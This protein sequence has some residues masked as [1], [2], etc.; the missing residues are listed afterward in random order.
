MH[1]LATQPGRIDNQAAVD[2]DQSPADIVILSAADTELACLAYAYRAW[3]GDKP[4]LRLANLTRLGHPFSVDLY[5][6]KTL[7]RAK[8]IVVRLLGGRAYW[9]YGIEEIAKLAGPAKIFLLPGDDKPDFDLRRLSRC[10]D[11]D[12]ALVGRYFQEG[13]MENAQSMLAMLSAMVGFSAA[14][15]PPLVLPRHGH[16]RLSRLDD[17]PRVLILFYRAL[18]QAG[19]TQAIDALIDALSARGLAACPLYVH[20]LKDDAAMHFVAAES[21]RAR[22]DL[23]LNLLSFAQGWDEAMYR[24]LFGDAPCLQV[25]LSG[26]SEQAW[27][28]DHRGLVPR[29]LA[30]QV[31]LPEIDGKVTTRA[32]AFKSEETV[33]DAVQCPIVTPRVLP[34]RVDYVCDLAR[35]WIDLRR[36]PASGKRIGIILANYPNRDGRIGNGVGLDVPR[37]LL[38]LLDALARD[39]YDVAAPA[40]VPALMAMLLSGPTNADPERASTVRLPLEDYRTFFETF[41][42]ERREEILA[43]WGAPD[44]DPFVRDGAFNLAVHALDQV[45][46]G[47]Q[48]ARGYQI[49]PVATYHDAT[50]PP[51]HYYLAFYCYLREK[52]AALIHL[53]KHGTA[54]WLPGK[55]LALSRTCWPEIVLGPTPHFYPFIVNDPGE[56]T[57]AKRR[58]AAVILDHLTPPLTRAGLHGDLLSLAHLIEEYYQASQLDPRRLKELRVRI[59]A[60]IRRQ[61]LD[62]DCGLRPGDDGEAALAKIDA[63]LCALKELQIRDGLHVFGERPGGTQRIDLLYALLHL[64]RGK[65]EGKDQSLL[66]ALALDKKVGFDPLECDLDHRTGPIVEELRELACDLLAGKTRP[67]STW[68]HILPVLD[69]AEEVGALLDRSA[70]LEIDHMLAGLRGEYVPPGPSGA[71]SRGRLDV[72]PTGRNFY[73]VD[74]RAIPTMTAWALGWKSASLLLERHRQDHGEWPRSIM[75]SAWGTANMRTGGDDIA[76]A[77]ALIGARPSWDE[78]GRVS[79]FEILPIGIL[80]RPRVDVTLRISGF[81]RDAFPTQIELFDS[82]VRAI[83]ALAEEGTD[84]ALA[85]HMAEE[86]TRLLEAGVPAHL[87]E[88]RAGHRVFGAKPG[89]YGTGL[90][91]LIDEGIWADVHDLGA[92]FI[93]WGSH[94]YGTQAQGDYVPEQFRERLSRAEA[95][96]HNQDNREHDIL[97]SDDYYQFEGGLT[98]AIRHVTGATPP[99]WHNDHSNPNRPKIAPLQ[100]E[101]GRIVRG[102]AANP[103]WIAGAMRHGYKGALEMAASVDY[104]FAFAATTGLVQDHHFQALYDAYIGN[105]KVREFLDDHNPAALREMTARFAEALRRGLWKSRSNSLAIELATEGIGH[106]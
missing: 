27:Q 23:I 89:A 36:M 22:P 60:E 82:A 100:E 96:V 97:D 80:G 84:N 25:L 79:G 8:I 16:Y 101:L 31:V 5:A 58:T 34:E 33:D 3:R 20:S 59:L 65:G 99:V 38:V 17:R 61:G 76:Q 28:A 6:E 103:K 54:E 35:A 51:P 45:L 91:T 48:P 78:T 66:R 4:S 42:P 81:F 62:K 21:Q 95:V 10:D 77:M 71:P 85:H 94:A 57:Q 2:L 75:L 49:D 87:A 29:D 13:G 32:I 46:V 56:G 98:A 15:S 9:P 14:P 52:C 67:D 44:S 92:L 86:R 70:R 69:Q 11:A 50:L 47:V 104:L 7:A 102:R 18:Y 106:G 83:A 68:T 39:G 41:P 72:L 90:Q 73:S 19:S 12:Y 63:H 1:L 24:T 105:E 74:T 37:S 88:L 93:E 64:P 55:A 53:G 26:E 43:R 40:D 30:M